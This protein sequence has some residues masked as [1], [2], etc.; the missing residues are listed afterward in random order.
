MAISSV[1]ISCFSQIILKKEALKKHDNLINEYL[2]INVIF[3][4]FL[5][6]LSTIF[7]TLS[8]KRLPLSLSPLWQS[9]GQI[10]IP[11]LSYY[12]LGEKIGKEKKKGILIIIVGA[13]IFSLA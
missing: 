3:A 7:S 8:L 1:L 13:F 12:L 2:N 6:F 10:A 9:L 4:Y 11:L 5:F